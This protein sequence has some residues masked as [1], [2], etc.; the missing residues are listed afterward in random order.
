MLDGRYRIDGVIGGGGMARVYRAEHLGISR[1]VAIK[2]LHAGLSRSRE[3][4]ERFR[5]EA[6]ASGRL[7]HPNIVTVTDFGVLSD[8]RA[9]LVMEALE[10]ETL[11]DRLEREGDVPWRAAVILLA[12]LLRGLRHAHDHGVIHRDIKP[13][14]IFL[15]QGDG[16]PLVKILDFGVAKLRASAPGDSRITQSGLTIG[17]PLYMSPEQTLDGQITPASD[18]YSSTVVLFEMITGEPPFY[19]DDPVATMKA[20]L[21]EPPPSLAEIAPELDIPDALEAIIRRGLAKLAVDRIPSAEAYLGMLDELGVAEVAEPRA[22]RA[23]TAPVVI[24]PA[25]A[26]PPAS[27]PASPPASPSL[28]AHEQEHA[29]PHDTVLEVTTLEPTTVEPSLAPISRRTWWLAAAGALAFAGGAI[30]VAQRALRSPDERSDAPLAPTVAAGEPTPD[31]PPP[32]APPPV[33]APDAKPRPD[34]PDRSGGTR[35]APRAGDGSGARTSAGSASDE[36]DPPRDREQVKRWMAD[37]NRALARGR[38]AEAGAQFQRAVA[39]DGT[40]HAAHAGLAE[41]AYNQGDFPRAVASARRAVALAP[42]VAAYR[43]T[44]AKSYYKVLR[45]GDAIA[46]WQRALE[47]DPSNEHARKNIDLARKKMRR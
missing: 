31:A 41:V 34:R 26:S 27:R 28:D 12:E 36:G 5:L 23:A 32:D 21:H 7:V 25:A 1:P 10:G 13:E 19:R 38:F 35:G 37:G 42:R 15:V 17:T 44:L 45:Y 47:L 29:H 46:E 39:A 24:E 9:F 33:P 14:N 30:F 16:G 22:R 4:V 11:A 43:M 18:L 6:T 40:A 8:G 2:V 20:H 3:A